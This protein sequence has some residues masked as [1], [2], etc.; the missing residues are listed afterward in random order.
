MKVSTA[1]GNCQGFFSETCVFS[2]KFP[3]PS[4]DNS[5]A[6]GRG[7]TFFVTTIL[8]PSRAVMF[9]QTKPCTPESSPHLHCQSAPGQETAGQSGDRTV[10]AAT[11]QGNWLN[12]GENL[13]LS[14]KHRQVQKIGGR[15]VSPPNLASFL[16][17]F[18]LLAVGVNLA[19]IV[20]PVTDCLV[21]H[22]PVVMLYWNATVF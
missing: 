16:A 11:R 15:H 18:Y 6:I 1:E 12:W 22:A 9:G 2:H 21:S 14:S 19:K 13:S 7:L 4:A 10:N 5:C 3:P 20:P 8:A 17:C